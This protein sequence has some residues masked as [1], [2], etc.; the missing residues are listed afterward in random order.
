MAENQTINLSY[1]TNV[2]ASAQRSYLGKRKIRQWMGGFF[3]PRHLDVCKSI[4]AVKQK[5]P[6]PDELLNDNSEVALQRANNI[7]SLFTFISL[8]DYMLTRRNSVAFA[9]ILTTQ[10]NE[11]FGKTAPRHVRAL[12]NAIKEKAYRKKI[13]EPYKDYNYAITGALNDLLVSKLREY[14]V[15]MEGT[16][17]T[18]NMLSDEFAKV[19]GRDTLAAVTPPRIGRV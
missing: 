14:G 7:Q 10:V 4:T 15:T 5:C 6:L 13:G 8:T 2:L 12:N 17:S 16:K 11:K 3:K 9:K 18:I 19:Q 1:W